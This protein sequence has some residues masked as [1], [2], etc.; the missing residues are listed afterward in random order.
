MIQSYAANTYSQTTIV[1]IQKSTLSLQE[2]IAEVESQTDFLFIFSK[3]DI[4]VECEMKIKTKSHQ[5]S[6][7]LKDVFESSDIT[8][9]FVEQY[10]TLR[11]KQE[12]LI[13]PHIA[14]N[15][16][17]TVSGIVKDANGEP[18]TGANIIEKGGG[19]NGTISN[20]DGSFT[21]EVPPGATLVVSFIGYITQEV[22][23]GNQTN[24]NVTLAEDSQVLE[25][26][27]VVGY[28]T[29]SRRKV[30]SS[31]SNIATEQIENL[32][33]ASVVNNL[34]GRTPGIIVTGNSGGPGNFSAISIRGGGTPIVVIDGVVSE[35]NDFRNIN[36]NDIENLTVLKDAA[37]AAIYGARAGNGILLV[38]TKRGANKT[39][40][41]NYNY[42]YSLSQP[43]VMQKKIGSYERAIFTNESY[44]NDGLAPPYSEEAVEKYRTG[45]D[46]YNYPNVD[47]QALCLK[48]F[49]PESLHNLSIRGGD[50]KNSYYASFGYYDQG[51]LYVFDTNWYKRYNGRLNLENNFENIGL[52]TT[53]SVSANFSEYRAPYSQ[54][55]TGYFSVWSHIQN[56]SPMNLDYNDLGIYAVGPNNPLTEMDPRS[57][58][59]L[60][61]AKDVNGMFTAEWQ[62]PGIKGLKLKSVSNYR[63]GF[64]R[65]KQWMDTAPQAAL[66]S[67]VPVA[68]NPSKLE[69][70]YAQSHSFTQQFL[71]D[72]EQRFLSDDFTVG[73]L[74]GYEINKAYNDY[75]DA[76]REN[77][78]LNVDQ[79]IAGPTTNL[80]NDGREYEYGRAGFIGRLKADYK[81][82][83]MLEASIRRDGSD[84][85]PKDKR[86]GT[87]YSVSGGW[88]LSDETFMEHLKENHMLDLFKIRGSYGVVGLDGTLT[89][90]LADSDPQKLLRYEYVPGY[91]LVQNAYVINNNLVQ[92][93]SE[94]GL[95]SP[96]I[97]WYTLASSN[98][99]FDFAMLNSALYGGFDYFYMYTSGFLASPSNT[100]YADPLG[101]SL[102]KIKTDGAKRRAGYEIS[103]GYKNTIDDFSYDV[104]GNFTFFNELWEV[105]PF[106]SEDVLKNPNLRNT[107]RTS[108]NRIGLHSLG[109]YTSEEDVLTSPRR[110]NSTNLRPGDIKYEDIDGNG[111]IDDA[112]RT[113]IGNSDMPRLT[114]GINLEL[115]YKDFF[116]YALFQG[117]GKRDF[118]LGDAVQARYGVVYP[119][120]KDYWTPTNTHA[121]YPRLLSGS[122]YNGDN[123]YQESDFWLVD[124]SYF[125]LKSLQVGYDFKKKLL[126]NVPF[127]SA[128][129]LIVSGS[130]L[131]TISKALDYYYDPES[132]GGG[133]NYD[134][135]Y[136][137]IYSIT[138]NLGF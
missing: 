1:H 79:F 13:L 101:T 58:Y 131:F 93:F 72:Y 75:M 24:V 42:S 32:P 121:L 111:V 33:S 67:S 112:D 26:V 41:V 91:N 16:R 51:T 99:G 68:K 84:W 113:I 88:T 87:F 48:E 19:T 14:Q 37:A 117:S 107:Q 118:Y 6:D 126:H 7:I 20:V 105:N 23:V 138:L 15:Q 102:P 86:W 127:L 106:E 100:I 2:L 122:S 95:V 129:K 21:L 56:T 40:S 124:A 90:N 70:R 85:F 137:R 132:A 11:K 82:K 104:S 108:Y 128:A 94:A 17:I 135:P 65:R 43:T 123:N 60:Q 71:A 12:A 59:D 36:Q 74:F 116:L 98:I 63:M 53:T 55:G 115:K 3:D 52:K 103:L 31:I 80:K 136:Q 69:E 66:G 8:Y 39:F 29:Q 27:V 73:A 5:I 34:G 64:S 18:I 76:S 77:Y 25:E 96:Y 120:Q 30:T 133:N 114:Y 9:K 119:Y 134:Y 22:A 92:G 38:T 89:A 28:G 81:A 50:N 4:N 47:W 61:E 10:I 57:G 44:L 35:Y 54:V 130:N 97:S 62:V 125:R 83:Y 109:Y 46:P 78:Q 49:A 110:L 45:S